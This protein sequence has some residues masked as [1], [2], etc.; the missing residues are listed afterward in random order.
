MDQHLP[1]ASTLVLALV[2]GLAV[3]LVPAMFRD[4]MME[5]AL[6]K[7][8]ETSEEIEEA[9]INFGMVE[10]EPPDL[11]RVNEHVE[12]R[13]RFRKYAQTLIDTMAAEALRSDRAARGEKLFA[14]KS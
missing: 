3:N 11:S 6:R 1:D 9:M 8:R 4:H 7:K 13:G 12:G 14:H 10:V 5:R 2:V